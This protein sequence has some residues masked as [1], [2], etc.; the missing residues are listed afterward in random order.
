MLFN[1]ADYNVPPIFA[2][3][4]A[5][6]PPQP[7]C[8]VITQWECEPDGLSFHHTLNLYGFR[9]PD[10]QIAPPADRP[11]ILFIGDSFVE[12]CGA[13]DADTL[14]RQF[15]GLLTGQPAPDVLNLGAAGANFPEYL[16]LVRDGVPLLRPHTVFLVICYNDLPAVSYAEPVPPPGGLESVYQRTFPA[17]NP[18]TPCAVEAVSLLLR[19]W[20]LPRRV[21]QGPFPFFAAVP[22]PANRFSSAPLIEGL[23][24]DLENAMRAGKANHYLPATLPMYERTLRLNYEVRGGAGYCLRFIAWF[25]REYGVRLNVVYIPFHVA[26][27]PGYI[28]AQVKLGGCAKVRLPAS[29]SD[30]AHRTQQRHLAKVCRDI[31]I[32]FVDTTDELIAGERERRL[33]WPT[34]GHCNAAGYRVIAEACA[35]CWVTAFSRRRAA[36]RKVASDSCHGFRN[37]AMIKSSGTLTAESS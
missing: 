32:P 33:F 10:F 29:F 19:G 12:G 20:V 34:D 11:R 2:T 18:Y 16:R 23:D 37:L 6:A 4:I 8:N 17:L 30:E 5:K 13:S 28:A 26:A 21:H 35:R 24:A 31:D 7:L 14:P 25:C 9:G 36:P 1:R 22:S 3:E 15:A 27:N